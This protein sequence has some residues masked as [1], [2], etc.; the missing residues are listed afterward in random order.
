MTQGKVSLKRFAACI[1][2]MQHPKISLQ[3]SALRIAPLRALPCLAWSSEFIEA[4]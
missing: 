2:D 4:P 3:T 1:I